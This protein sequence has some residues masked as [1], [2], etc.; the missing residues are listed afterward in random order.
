MLNFLKVCTFQQNPNACPQANRKFNYPPWN[1]LKEKIQSVVELV[2]RKNEILCGSRLLV[3]YF[4]VSQSRRGS[5]LSLSSSCACPLSRLHAHTCV[6]ARIML[7]KKLAEFQRNSHRQGK[8]NC[9]SSNQTHF[10][11]NK[12]CR[13][14]RRQLNN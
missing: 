11:C 13:K 8:S 5:R 12:K 10:A 4:R 1:E 9:R 6:R 2:R 3:S 14:S 7:I